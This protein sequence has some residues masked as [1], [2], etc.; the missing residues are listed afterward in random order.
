MRAVEHLYNE[1]MADDYNRRLRK[2]CHALHHWWRLHCNCR[3]D[4]EDFYKGTQG[5]YHN[6]HNY[7]SECPETA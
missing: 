3:T 4:G 5:L 1:L 2:L 7:E 6:Y